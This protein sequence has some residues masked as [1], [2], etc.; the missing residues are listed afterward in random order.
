MILAVV[1]VGLF[2]ASAANAD[3]LTTGPTSTLYITDYENGPSVLWTVQGG[4]GVIT[5]TQMAGASDTAI[6]VTSTIKTLALNLNTGLTTTGYQYTLNGAFT[7]TTYPAPAA[8]QNAA[9]FDGA[10]DGTNNYAVDAIAG[11]V[12]KFNGN[13]GNPQVLF[14]SSIAAQDYF[15]GIA[16][17][18]ADNT[19]WFTDDDNSTVYHYS[20][21]GAL[22][23]SFALAGTNPGEDYTGLALDPAD[24]TLWTYLSANGHDFS[25][26]QQ[27]SQTGVLLSDF[28]FPHYVN[29]MEFAEA[30][31]TPIPSA[32]LLF[33]PGLAGLAFVRRRFGK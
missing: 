21:S 6:A 11:T 16:Y 24:G 25:G 27:Y 22:L 8:V 18:T 13:W 20:L 19:L 31:P 26:L 7:G 32:L 17:N 5:G 33:A 28:A 9:F 3:V 10:S 30:T 1:V 29:G 14:T 2:A 23:G 15:L 12:Y 4:T